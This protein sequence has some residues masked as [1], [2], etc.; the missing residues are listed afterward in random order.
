MK[1]NL[2]PDASGPR[3]ALYPPIE[4]FRQQLLDMPG[5][6]RVYVEQCGKP[7]GAP[8]VVLHGGPGG[9]CSPGMRRFFDPR[10]YR[11]VLF[12]QRGCG[13]SSPHAS[14]ENNTTWDLVADI[15][16]IRVDLGIER[17]T[18][19]RRLLGRLPRAALRPGPPRPGRGAGAARRL[20]HDPGRARLVLRR[21]RR[22]LLA[23]AVARP[24]R[25]W[26]PRR[27]ADDLIAAYHKRL[28]GADSAEQTRFARAWAGWE[29]A[30]A[31]LDPGDGRGYP[32]AAYALAFAR[33]ENHYFINGGFL[34]ERRPGDART[35]RASH[36]VPGH[37]VQGRYDM[38]CPPHTAQALHEAWPGSTLKMIAAAGHALSEPG[39]TAELVAVMD[40][41]R[42]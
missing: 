39:I 2:S 4:P 23:R 26:R 31:V 15:E 25:T 40:G 3:S 22:R 12:D 29:S 35:C 36:E 33:L 18:R 20:H 38:I 11:A 32:S 7:D 6:H 8:V 42:G 19:V 28:F 41:L 5:G 9:G 10:H 34:D 24:S 14:V 21:R 1:E 27:S 30:L 37:I 17:W 16:R 13:R